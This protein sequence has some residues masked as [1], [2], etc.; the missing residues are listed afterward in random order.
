M[1]S[2]EVSPSNMTTLCFRLKHFNGSIIHYILEKTGYT[3]LTEYEDMCY[4]TDKF[5]H[6]VETGAG[7][8]YCDYSEI[9]YKLYRIF[10]LSIHNLNDEAKHY[11][12]TNCIGMSQIE[13]ELKYPE[14]N[15]LYVWI[16]YKNE[17]ARLAGTVSVDIGLAPGA[18]EEDMVELVDEVIQ[19]EPQEQ[20]KSD[21]NLAGWIFKMNHLTKNSYVLIP[22]KK[23]QMI[24]DRNVFWGDSSQ[25]IND[26]LWTPTTWHAP[27]ESLHRP[28]YYTNS[29]SGWIIS[30]RYR[31]ELLDAGAKEHK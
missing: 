23:I 13:Y 2:I 18:E 20:M 12:M 7:T 16:P 25:L 6:R 11:L 21:K 17:E 3:N 27:V 4:N 29:V 1:S 19:I 31:T 5:I 24:Q 9:D 22:P 10:Q 14:R 26:W 15:K 28:I 8:I 30:L